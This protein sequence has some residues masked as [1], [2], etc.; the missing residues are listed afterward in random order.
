MLKV[1]FEKVFETF[2][3]ALNADKRVKKHTFFP[4]AK[5]YFPTSVRK[6]NVMV[7][8]TC[9][10]NSVIQETFFSLDCLALSS[11]PTVKPVRT[12][13][14]APGFLASSINC[15]RGS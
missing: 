8:V 14:L 7:Q 15:C 6:I 1:H 3:H 2:F 5:I 4:N 10:R 11:L 12:E 9:P 13:E